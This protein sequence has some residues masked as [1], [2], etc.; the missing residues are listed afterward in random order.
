MITMALAAFGPVMLIEC[1]FVFAAI[2]QTRVGRMTKIATLADLCDAGR[3]RGV[4]SM[5][6]IATRRAQIATVEQRVAMHACAI[7]RKL[8]RRKR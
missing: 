2:E 6:S 4:I 8:C 1:V 3:A 7:F 5:T